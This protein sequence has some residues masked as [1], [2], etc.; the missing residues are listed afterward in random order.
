MQTDRQTDRYTHTHTK[1]PRTHHT[2][3]THTQLLDSETQPSRLGTESAG[4]VLRRIHPPRVASETVKSGFPGPC[5]H[6]ND[7][8]GHCHAGGSMAAVATVG[9]SNDSQGRALEAFGGWE[10]R[11]ALHR[12]TTSPQTTQ[13]RSGDVE[14]GQRESSGATKG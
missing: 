5:L 4:R 12:T 10:G 11:E 8:A 9:F 2:T 6:G 13:H 1:N 14:Q 7:A 3:H